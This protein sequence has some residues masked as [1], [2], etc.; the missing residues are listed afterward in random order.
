MYALLE[1]LVQ[2]QA[3]KEN[4]SSWIFAISGLDFWSQCTNILLNHQFPK[5]CFYQIL[6][7]SKVCVVSSSYNL[8]IVSPAFLQG[9]E[10]LNFDMKMTFPKFS[11]NYLGIILSDYLAT[12]LQSSISLHKKRSGRLPNQ[13][14]N[15]FQLEFNF[16]TTLH[17]QI[18]TLFFS[19]KNK[20][21]R[22][23]KIQLSLIILNW[24]TP[25]FIYKAE[26]LPD[27][28]KDR[29]KLMLLNCFN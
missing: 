10:N 13:V 12:G 1:S 22:I 28:D 23:G 2:G 8:C 5:F 20:W 25:F 18:L 17:T 11:S 16:F 14:T 29:L 26:V 19:H 4:M 3:L 15:D 9:I 24:L 7:V 21:C 27:Y 6:P